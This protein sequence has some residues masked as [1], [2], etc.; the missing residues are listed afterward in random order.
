MDFNFILTPKA[1]KAGEPA[2][3]H[4]NVHQGFRLGLG[5]GLDLDDLSGIVTH[6]RYVTNFGTPKEHLTTDKRKGSAFSILADALAKCGLRTAQ[7]GG[8]QCLWMLAS[9]WVACSRSA[10]SCTCSLGPNVACLGAAGCPRGLS[11]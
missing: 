11:T 2:P 10:R 3:A 7:K 5:L 9:S 8:A 4:G 1:S 6:C